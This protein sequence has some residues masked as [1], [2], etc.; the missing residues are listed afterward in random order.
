MGNRET[1]HFGYEGSGGIALGPEVSGLNTTA[2]SGLKASS[3][4]GCEMPCS[5]SGEWH[6]THGPFP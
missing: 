1:G 2:D 3:P 4:M 5:P 6:L